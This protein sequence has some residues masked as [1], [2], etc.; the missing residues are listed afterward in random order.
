MSD[1]DTFGK[2]RNENIV[3]LCKLLRNFDVTLCHQARLPA[4]AAPV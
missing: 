4:G 3:K 2:V 1:D